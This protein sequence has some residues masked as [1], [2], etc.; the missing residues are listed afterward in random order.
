VSSFSKSFFIV[1]R[2][3]AVLENEGNGHDEACHDCGDPHVLQV[4]LHLL[5]QIE[6][7]NLFGDALCH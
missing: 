3:E 6:Q 5:F 7:A 2:P 1:V 4:A